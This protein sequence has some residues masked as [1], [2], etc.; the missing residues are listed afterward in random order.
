MAISELD[1]DNAER[2]P[3]SAIA[4]D[5]GVEVAEPKFTPGPYNADDGDGQYFCV[6][7]AK[8]NPLAVL[9]EIRGPVHIVPLPEDRGQSEDYGRFAEHKANAHLFAAAPD[10]YAAHCAN[11]AVLEYLV[12][13]IDARKPLTAEMFDKIFACHQRSLAAAAKAR[14][15]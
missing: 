13:A 5:R 10:M 15:A 9:A 2:I 12:N 11:A 6:F 4:G 8:G 1:L 14:A 7:D 3:G